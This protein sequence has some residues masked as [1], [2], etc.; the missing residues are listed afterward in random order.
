LWSAD[1]SRLLYLIGNTSS[2]LASEAVVWTAATSANRVVSGVLEQTGYLT[3][4][5][6]SPD[7]ERVAYRAQENS[8]AAIELF[9]GQADESGASKVSS[10]AG[11]LGYA[12]APDG[13][14]IAFTAQAATGGPIEL[15]AGR[16]EAGSDVEASTVS[17]TLPDFGTGLVPLVDRFFWSEDG[18]RLVFRAGTEEGFLGPIRNFGLFSVADEGGD[19]TRLGGD[20][21]TARD[22]VY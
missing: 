9:V 8:A 6:W 14:A 15:Y 11:V 18:E 17:G 21:K 13:A 4:P 2:A 22:I 20:L 1:G 12:W 19:V 3:D 5:Q 10:T 16:Y 7:G